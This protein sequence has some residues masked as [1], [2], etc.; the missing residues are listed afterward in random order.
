[1]DIRQTGKMFGLSQLAVKRRLIAA[2]IIGCCLGT[3][4]GFARDGANQT[5]LTDYPD[6]VQACLA[7]TTGYGLAAGAD[8]PP[9]QRWGGS[10]GNAGHNTSRWFFR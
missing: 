4:A 2:I 8:T 5:G 9:S 10:G 6:F 3:S 1:M 7:F